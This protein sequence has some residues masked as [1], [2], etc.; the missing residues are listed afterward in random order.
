M[1]NLKSWVIFLLPSDI[2]WPWTGTA[3]SISKKKWLWKKHFLWPINDKCFFLESDLISSQ[4][5]FVYFQGLVFLTLLHSD[6]PGKHWAFSLPQF[7]CVVFWYCCCCD[8]FFVRKFTGTLAYLTGTMSHQGSL[9]RN[10]CV[11]WWGFLHLSISPFP[12]TPQNPTTTQIQIPATFGSRC[13]LGSW[14]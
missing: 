5:F 12:L 13:C 10:H 1:T 8:V 7:G 14:I 4:P 6:Q 2:F 9:R 3:R 11:L